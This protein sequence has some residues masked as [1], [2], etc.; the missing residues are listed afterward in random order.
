[1]I[2]SRTTVAPAFWWMVGGVLLVLFLSGLFLVFAPFL[3]GFVWGT[4]LVLMTWPAYRWLHRKC[5]LRET[6]AAFLMTTGIGA[7]LVLTAVPVVRELGGELYSISKE[8][9]AGQSFSSPAL[10]RAM[11]KLHFDEAY[12]ATIKALG[13][14]SLRAAGK[15]TNVLLASLFN[16]GIMIFSAYFFYRH[17]SRLIGELQSVLIRNISL[18]WQRV[19]TL[20]GDTIKGVVYGALAT[21]LA[22]G[23]LAGIGYY[24]AGAPVPALLGLVTTLMSFVPFGAPMVYLPVS[25]YL[26]LSVGD[27]SAGIGLL[28]WG[29][30]VV[31]AIDNILR[32]LFISQTMKLPL[33]LVFVGVVGGILAFGL[34]G[35]FIGPVLVALAHAAWRDIA[36]SSTL[37][38]KTE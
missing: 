12:T 3:E 20:T 11:Q 5:Q 27:W 36:H 21:A 7:M 33:L 37:G 14:M 15:A 2:T 1:M 8:L 22:Q 25:L 30:L 6:I 38:E 26:I 28:I 34:I 29:V 19:F 9:G 10:N 32:P 24:V 13:E 17:G 16:I 4:I 31:S 18:N 23:I 35:L